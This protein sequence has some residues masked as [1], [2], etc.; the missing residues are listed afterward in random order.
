MKPVRLLVRA[1]GPYAG[2]QLFNFADLGDRTFFLIHGPT[3]A[4]KTS[5]LDAMCYAL[6]GDTSGAERAGDQMRSHHAPPEVPTEVLFEF[7]LG[8]HRYR[9]HRAPDQDRPRKKGSGLTRQTAQATLSRVEG[10]GTETVLAG[11]PSKVREAVERLFNFKSE[12]FRQVVMLPQGKFRELLVASS[13]DR[14]GILQA[15]FQTELYERIQDALKE[16]AKALRTELEKLQQERQLLLKQAAVDSVDALEARRGQ[17]EARLI[18]LRQEAERANVVETAAQERLTAARKANEL[19][20]EREAAAAELRLIEALLPEVQGQESE[21]AEARRAACLAP[22]EQMFDTRRREKADRQRDLAATDQSLAMATAAAAT[23]AKTLEAARARE[24]ERQQLEAHCTRLEELQTRV[25]WLAAART[26]AAD[27]QKAFKD[28]DGRYAA[29]KGALETLQG[30]LETKQRALATLQT[31]AATAAGCRLAAAAAQRRLKDRQDLA[32]L[33]ADLQKAADAEAAAAKTR[34]E[35]EAGEASA[36]AMLDHLQRA[37]AAGQAG[38]LAAALTTGCPCPVCGSTT[39]PAKAATAADLPGQAAIETQKV[40]C[41]AAAADARTAAQAHAKAE[42][43]VLVL[44]T[45]EGSLLEALGGDAELPVAALQKL[46]TETA[47]QS[48]VAGD[49]ERALAAE[50]KALEEVRAK[51]TG[52]QGELSTLQSAREA[53]QQAAQ[54]AQGLVDGQA[55]AIPAEYQDSARLKAALASGRAQRD[56]LKAAFDAAAAGCAQADSQAA[57]ARAHRDAAGASLKQAEDAFGAAAA[58]FEEQVLAGGFA[59]TEAYRVA[60]RTSEQVAALEAAMAQFR[61]KL[62][63]ASERAVRARAAAEGLGAVDLRVY[64]QEVQTAKAARE[65]AIRQSAEYRTSLDQV[66]HLLAE[67]ARTAARIAELDGAYSLYGRL[68]EV[69]NG[70][71]PARITFQRFV[72]GWLLDDVLAAASVRL[73][74]MTKGRYALRRKAAP[75]DARSGAGLDLEVDDAHTGVARAVATLSGGEGFLA[76][77]ALALGLADV[78]QAYAGGIRLETMFIDEGFGSLDPEALDLAVRSLVDL[79]QGGRLVGIISHVPELRERIDAWLEITAG[80]QGSRAQF[81]L[82]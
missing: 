79:Q 15:L 78:V 48:K 72:L 5:V 4:G 8:P 10:D 20:G 40:A 61:Q 32:T 60:K 29:A 9:V 13:A 30:S 64:E 77:L 44:R 3:G 17:L 47:A 62:Q 52:A 27:A 36:R 43:A 18:E 51:L 31:T 58:A 67:L 73:R 21:L 63:A 56:T 65:A 22:A 66:L 70:Q 2:E 12:Q 74:T 41:D 75:A 25:A 11:Q 33:G 50:A 24:P 57:A 42:Q 54:H 45:R 26:A 38:L 37:W 6:Y 23:A 7:Q 49:A 59:H 34:R 82:A 81:V 68:A 28:I 16:R 19:V 1:F 80:R 53:A 14:E 69:A 39:H 71:N 46:A 76:S 35:A 55:A